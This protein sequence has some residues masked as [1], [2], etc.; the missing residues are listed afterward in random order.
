VS[1]TA[2]A[3]L[4][5]AVVLLF[6]VPMSA[7]LIPHGNVFAGVSY[8][9]MS[10]VTNRASYRGWEGTAEFFPFARYSHL[11]FALDGSGFYRNDRYGSINQ[12][13]GMG[14]VRWSWSFGKFRPF[15]EG[16]GG[17]QRVNSSGIIYTHPVYGGGGGVDYKLPFKNFSWRFQG[18]YMRASYSSAIENDYRASTGIVWRF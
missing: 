4:A 18:D 1:K 13:N 6:S 14:A 5:F 12:Y 2:L 8:G 11:S 17:Y 3:V 15:L 16:I 9:Q 10:D 7:Q